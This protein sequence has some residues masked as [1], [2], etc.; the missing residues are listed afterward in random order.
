MDP[1]FRQFY[2]LG[3]GLVKPEFTVIILLIKTIHG[4]KTHPMTI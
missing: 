1:F 3:T 4:T 2:R